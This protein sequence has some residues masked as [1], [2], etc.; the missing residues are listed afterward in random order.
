[1][2]KYGM[3][4]SAQ[5]QAAIFWV[6]GGSRLH[7]VLLST[8]LGMIGRADHCSQHVFQGDGQSLWG[9]KAEDSSTRLRF[10]GREVCEWENEV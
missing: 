2:R 7:A 10:A 9:S 5:Q 6:G 1:M 8:V 4:E 3:E